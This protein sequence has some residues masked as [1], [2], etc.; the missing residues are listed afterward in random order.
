MTNDRLR[1][2]LLRQGLTPD[3]AAEA[4]RVD[5][6]TIERWITKDRTPYPK[7]RHAL[8]A[9]LRESESF[10]WPDALGPER[11][12][13]VATSEVVAVYPHRH[14]MPREVWSRLIDSAANQLDILVYAGLFL[15]ENHKLIKTLRAKAQ[16]GTK[17]RF[18]F[19]DPDSLNVTSRSKEEKIGPEAIAAKIR[20]AI[21]FFQSLSDEP[22]VELRLHETTLY[23]SI[24]R[25]DSEMLVNTHVYGLMAAH[26]PVLHLRQLAGGDLFDTYADSF[27]SVWGDSKP[28]PSELLT[29]RN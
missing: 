23:N 6:K 29:R 12:A 10:L 1:D 18:L 4:I 5:A 13:E 25:F 11:A 9:L 19:G 22:G 16:A 24:Y 14:E 27:N 8:A 7:H 28:L 3:T 2:A 17:I 26:S 15:T 21:F 20:N